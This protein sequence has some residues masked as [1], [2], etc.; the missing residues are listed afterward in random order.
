MASTTKDFKCPV[1]GKVVKVTRSVTVIKAGLPPVT[2]FVSCSGVSHCGGEVK[3]NDGVSYN[4]II[5]P[6]HKA[7]SAQ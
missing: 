2:Q 7:V 3:H 4:W 1:A 5:C 6:V